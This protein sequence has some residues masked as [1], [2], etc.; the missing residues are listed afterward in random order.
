VHDDQFTAMGPSFRDSGFPKT[1]FS[2]SSPSDFLDG[3]HVQAARCG[4]VGEGLQA[5]AD[6]TDVGS[7]FPGVGVEGRGVNLG[8][9]G[10]GRENAIASVFGQGNRCKVGV[11][12]VA[13]DRR[14]DPRVGVIGA[15]VKNLGNPL[16]TFRRAP[17]PADGSGTGVL[18]TSGTGDGVRGTSDTG[19][20]VRGASSMGNGVHGKSDEGTGVAAESIS[21]VAVS[22]VSTSNRAGVFQSGTNIAQISLVPLEQKT[23]EPELPKDGNVGDILLILNKTK[24]G[25]TVVHQKCSLWLC[26]PS[27]G[28]LGWSVSW[29][30]IQLGRVVTGTI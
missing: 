12:G 26:V 25:H 14:G 3:V 7:T 21:G 8:V 10:V 17:E 19:D 16:Q 6:T 28:R 24:L 11:L 22:A 2:T 15:S 5:S 4:V 29:Q 27:A 18:G 1:A 9:L 30:E 13:M 23:A 20:G